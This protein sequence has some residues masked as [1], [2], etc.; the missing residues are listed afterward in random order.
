MYV[1]GE[2][3][4]FR[5]QLEVFFFFPF[6]AVISSA[7]PPGNISHG[8]SPLS[9]PLD[10]STLLFSSLTCSPPS[11]ASWYIAVS[12]NHP[13]ASTPLLH[14]SALFLAGFRLPRGAVASWNKSFSTSPAVNFTCK[15]R[16]Q[17]FVYLSDEKTKK[18]KTPDWGQFFILVSCSTINVYLCSEGLTLSFIHLIIAP[19]DHPSPS[20]LYSSLNLNLTPHKSAKRL[21]LPPWAIPFLLF[22]PSKVKQLEWVDGVEP[23]AEQPEEGCAP[24]KRSRRRRSDKG[25]GKRK[26][27]GRIFKKSPSSAF[28]ASLRER[29][30][31]RDDGRWAGE[32]REEARREKVI[33]EAA[34]PI[35]IRHDCLH[36]CFTPRVVVH[37]VSVC[38]FAS[39]TWLMCK[40][41]KERPAWP[42]RESNEP[43]KQ[44]QSSIYPT[45]L[46]KWFFLYTLASLEEVLRFVCDTEYSLN[47]VQMCSL[48]Q[49]QLRVGLLLRTVILYM[50]VAWN[51]K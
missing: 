16:L 11:F 34:F 31:G 8:S 2:E 9:L 37:C 42:V 51:N 43:H 35:H 50:L 15:T 27:R 3:F 46:N 4:L 48:K 32:K 29:Q 49:M 36:C 22:S 21:S 6:N 26:G 13:A 40:I 33:T 14:F 5:L 19:L 20:L 45:R 12:D 44:K 24:K 47:I 7:S 17:G 30:G 39:V 23:R 10:C 1:P 41:N 18:N 28:S 38:M 25:F